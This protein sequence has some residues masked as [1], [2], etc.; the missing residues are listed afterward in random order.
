M[1]IKRRTQKNFEKRKRRIFDRG[2]KPIKR[3]VGED[4]DQRK[5]AEKL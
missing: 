3:G 2:E 5:D 4:E 1:K